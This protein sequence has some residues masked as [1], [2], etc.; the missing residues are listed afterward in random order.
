[1]DR[2]QLHWIIPDLK[3]IL[4]G[5]KEHKI[6]PRIRCKGQ[7]PILEIDLKYKCAVFKGPWV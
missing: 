2:S 4:E 1:M 7:D 5:G 3:E 6:R